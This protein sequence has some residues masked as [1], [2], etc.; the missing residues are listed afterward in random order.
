M[1]NAR[2]GDE[3]LRVSDAAGRCAVFG[4]RWSAH[5]QQKEESFSDTFGIS[6]LAARTVQPAFK[7]S[8]RVRRLLTPKTD[9]K[10]QTGDN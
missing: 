8:C 9:S 4:G 7:I 3:L 1:R 2:T 6:K 10:R 5:S